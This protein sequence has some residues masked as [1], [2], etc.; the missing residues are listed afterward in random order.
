MARRRDAHG[1]IHSWVI[2]LIFNVKRGKGLFTFLQ[3]IQSTGII[4]R[5]RANGK[6]NGKKK[7]EKEGE[8][9]K[10]VW[11]STDKKTNYG[12]HTNKKIDTIDLSLSLS[13]RSLSSPPYFSLTKYKTVIV[14]YL[15][16]LSFPPISSKPSILRVLL[17]VIYID[18][19]PPPNT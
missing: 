2:I 7:K 12:S 3:N 9:R 13:L 15:S 17:L 5:K 18:Q 11:L 8:N 6:R 19:R 4:G 16:F 1:I 10:Y 14:L